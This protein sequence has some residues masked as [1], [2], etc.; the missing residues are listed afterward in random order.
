MFYEKR[1]GDLEKMSGRRT[2]LEHEDTLQRLYLHEQRWEE[3]ENTKD[4]VFQFVEHSGINR[5]QWK[6]L[7]VRAQARLELGHKDKARTDALRARD[8]FDDVLAMISGE[9]LKECYRAQPRAMM[10]MDIIAATD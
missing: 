8:C 4:A 2:W 6:F 5:H 7:T 9:S 3:I 1:T 10:L